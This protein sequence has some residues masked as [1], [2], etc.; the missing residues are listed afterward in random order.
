[1]TTTSAE[2]ATLPARFDRPWTVGTLGRG[3]AFLLAELVVLL[4]AQGR[5]AGTA[6]ADGDIGAGL[7]LV[8][9][10]LGGAAV[11]GAVD[12]HR[13]D[14]FG[15]VL[16]RWAVVA[17]LAGCFPPLYHAAVGGPELSVLGSD[18]VEVGGFTATVVLGAA[19]LGCLVGVLTDRR[20]PRR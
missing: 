16:A 18:L 15:P 1:M 7:L 12:G 3:L 13:R 11:W 5:V 19:T 9:L 6:A 20:A 2:A 4:L 10:G 14:R 8:A 17:V